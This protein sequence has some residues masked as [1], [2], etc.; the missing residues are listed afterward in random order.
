[1]ADAGQEA[2]L[3]LVDLIGR[4][5]ATGTEIGW[6]PKPGKDDVPDDQ[7]LPGDVTWH[8]SAIYRGAKVHAEGETAPAVADAL[9]RK[10]L[11]GGQCA[12]CKRRVVL[13]GGRTPRTCVWR[14]SGPRWDRDA[15]CLKDH[16]PKTMEQP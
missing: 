5:G 13:F 15:S 2:V 9:A 11:D 7:L 16:P 12:H 1:M 10:L 4:T 8:A 6:L 3:A 14:R